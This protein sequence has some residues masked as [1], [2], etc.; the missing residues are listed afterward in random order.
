[1]EIRRNRKKAI[2][3]I[4]A[5][6]ILVVFAITFGIVIMTFGKAQIQQEAVWDNVLQ[7]DSMWCYPLESSFKTKAREVYKD[8]GRFKSQAKKRCYNKKYFYTLSK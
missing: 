5:T 7:K 1:M 6:L 8:Y 4:V 2:A 3:P